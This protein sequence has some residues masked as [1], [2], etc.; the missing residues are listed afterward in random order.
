M[1]TR[2]EVEVVIHRGECMNG[3]TLR[4]GQ[5]MYQAFRRGEKIYVLQGGRYHGWYFVASERWVRE[6]T[7]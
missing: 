6:N 7:M 4:A 2:R 5:S 3:V 1:K